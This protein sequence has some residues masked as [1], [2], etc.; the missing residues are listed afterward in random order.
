MLCMPAAD[1]A[2]RLCTCVRPAD[3]APVRLGKTFRVI[4]VLAGAAMGPRQTKTWIGN[5]AYDRV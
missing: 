2:A 1:L 3:M 5:I 4:Q